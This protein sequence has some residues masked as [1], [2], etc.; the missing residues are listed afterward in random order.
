M[1]CAGTVKCR[2]H[3]LTGYRAEA[4]KDKSREAD[5]LLL[6][7]EEEEEISSEGQAGTRAMT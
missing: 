2:E 4:E 7:G 3:P 5:R 6:C 1:L